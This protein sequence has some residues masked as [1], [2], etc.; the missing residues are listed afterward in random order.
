LLAVL[1]EDNTLSDAYFQ[2]GMT[3]LRSFIERAQT[4]EIT[5]DEW[6][7]VP[8]GISMNLGGPS[9][10]FMIGVIWSSIF[11]DVYDRTFPELE[12]VGFADKQDIQD[13]NARSE[14]DAK[15]CRIVR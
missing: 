9:I 8:I 13:I 3:N 7:D 11:T 5:E 14:F 6:S 2:L 12:G 1:F 15:N 4:G 10:D